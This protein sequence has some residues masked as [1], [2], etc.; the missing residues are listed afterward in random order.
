V[1]VT[2]ADTDLIAFV[3][4][5]GPLGIARVPAADAVPLRA[6]SA[7]GRS[8]DELRVVSAGDVDGDGYTDLLLAGPEGLA[9][10]LGG[11][12]GVASTARS[13]LPGARC[14]AAG[15]GDL[16]GDGHADVVAAPAGC[17]DLVAVHGGGADGLSLMPSY[18]FPAVDFPLCPRPLLAR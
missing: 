4:H 5:G 15:V 13:T 9:L 14:A 1:A 8:A 6:G 2:G 3:Y 10:F 18:T 11:S 7:A 16:D 17:G 12:G